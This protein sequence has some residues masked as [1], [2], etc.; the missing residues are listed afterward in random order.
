MRRTLIALAATL[1]VSVTACGDDDAAPAPAPAPAPDANDPDAADDAGDQDCAAGTYGIIDREFWA[2]AVLAG[3]EG[4]AGTSIGGDLRLELG[5]D[6]SAAMVL[7]DWT[8]R[9]SFPGQSETVRG[10]NTGDVTGSWSRSD[11]GL[12]FT[13]SRDAVSASFTLESAAGSMAVP[14]GESLMPSTGTYPLIVDCATGRAELRAVTF[15]WPF[16]RR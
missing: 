5:A 16:Q 2:N 1:L 9:L 8:F 3:G 10:V 14:G 11:D 6:G 15:V 12:Q 4:G 7:D 13:A